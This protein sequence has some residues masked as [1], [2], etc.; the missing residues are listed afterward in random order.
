MK[1]PTV[2]ML[3]FAVLVSFG[4]A[5]PA[6]A[7]E[8]V[9][10]AQAYELV[11]NGSTAA[12]AYDSATVYYIVDVR[13]P[14]EWRWVGHPGVNKAGEGKGLDLKVFNVAYQIDWKKQFV[15][16]PSF[17]NEIN[18]LFGS[19]KENVVLIL[20]CRSGAR[21]IAAANVLEPLGYRVMNM[22][23]GFEGGTDAKGYR[24][25]NGWKIDGM[26]YNFSA[27]GAYAD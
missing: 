4:M 23:N 2:L 5:M 18:E 12:I 10:T 19:V 9:S 1:K 8:N 16:N 15:V 26:P 27:L 24:V 20:M 14:E 21:S 11:M 6:A 7:Y 3:C 17:V 13:T 25:R 22:V